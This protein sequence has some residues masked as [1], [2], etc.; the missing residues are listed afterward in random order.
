MFSSFFIYTDADADADTVAD[1]NVD[2]D[3][4]DRG[5]YIDNSDGDDGNNSGDIGNGGGNCVSLRRYFV[6]IL[7]NIAVAA[8]RTFKL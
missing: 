6:L 3:A 2:A 7:I 5:D 1:V 8:F 4:D